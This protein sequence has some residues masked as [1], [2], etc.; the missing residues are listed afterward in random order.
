MSIPD[1]FVENLQDVFMEEP[2]HPNFIVQQ[3]KDDI[4]K[5]LKVRC[6]SAFWNRYCNY[7]YSDNKANIRQIHIE[8]APIIIMFDDKI[9]NS[10]I[11]KLAK[12]LQIY[13][14][15]TFVFDELSDN[16][17]ACIVTG[18]KDSTSFYFPLC[19]IPIIDLSNKYVHDINNRLKAK[20]IDRVCR[21]YSP[22]DNIPI[23]GS[24]S[25]KFIIG[26]DELN[27]DS[28]DLKVIEPNYFDLEAHT[29]IEQELIDLESLLNEK[30]NFASDD[31]TGIY[32]LPIILS[33]DYWRSTTDSIKRS[34][35]IHNYN[36][37]KSRNYDVIS[38]ITE[39]STKDDNLM[40]LKMY[41]KFLSMW[42]SNRIVSER[43]WKLVGRAFYSLENGTDRGLNGWIDVI[44][45]SLNDARPR[46]YLSKVNLVRVCRSAYRGIRF[47]EIDIKTLAW[48]ARIDSPEKY[49]R[50]HD[51]WVTDALVGSC[52]AT[53]S[54]IGK[55]FYREYWLEY[56]TY[57]GS[58]KPIFYKYRNHRLIKDY[59][60]IS[61]KLRMSNSFL[62]LY[63]HMR[64]DLAKQQRKSDINQATYDM[65]FEK[66][67]LAINKL[68]QQGFK[69]RLL[70]ELSERFYVEGLETFIDRDP[71]ITLVRN[72]VIS[73]TTSSIHF[74]DGKPQ[75]YVVK[76]FS[77]SYRAEYTWDHPCVKAMMDWSYITFVDPDTIKFHWKFLASLLRGGNNDKKVMFWSGKTGN[78]MKTT[79]QRLIASVLGE[80]CIS[81]PINY[82]TL[83]KGAANGATP[84]EV[85]LDGARLMFSEEAEAEVPFLTSIIKSEVGNE[86]RQIRGLY[87]EA[88]DIIPQHKCVI[89]VNTIPPISREGA[90]VE[91]V[92]ITPF[93]S[94]VSMDAPDD[95][96]EQ[97]RLR[98]FKRD[99][100]FD[101]QLPFLED[102]TLWIKFNTY[103]VYLREGI[104]NQPPDVTR[105]IHEYWESIDRY[106]IFIRE[107]IVKD[108]DESIE[109]YDLY[110]QFSRWHQASYKRLNVPDKQTAIPEFVK[111]LG[112]LIDGAWHGFRLNTH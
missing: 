42:D 13:L 112:E 35:I 46:S 16:S 91:R 86:K 71:E 37:F 28:L 21:V 80:K 62:S 81:M 4:K 23:Y 5:Q 84:A 105:S 34:D 87:Q 26:Y 77:A 11:Q 60:G 50:W 19:R 40:T 109:A 41:L 3:G 12:V 79:W 76:S 75:D 59:H 2:D 69:Q 63:Y 39:Q 10:E 99:P 14:R 22:N 111:R 78:N 15:D 88:K 83:G 57:I 52:S 33:I 49:E 43:D 92:V 56:M 64:S 7:V 8:I 103:P 95:I 68:K 67:T 24:T 18:G 61:L 29:K 73:A 51:E 74:R 102:A 82:F 98:L 53:E 44:K 38:I 90:T 58:S 20:S 85:R 100:F 54:D 17:Y 25:E 30:V 47:A 108:I 48:Y 36:K 6:Y 104:Q 97:I 70:S 66:I 107:N 101:M 110:V 96:D 89:V 27:G 93:C 31:S 32:W 9:E 94:Q 1:S 72:G 55:A 45:Q 106:S 65:A